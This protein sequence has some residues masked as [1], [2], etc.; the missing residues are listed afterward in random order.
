[1]APFGEEESMRRRFGHLLLSAL[2]TCAGVSGQQ[3]HRLKPG[4]TSGLKSPGPIGTQPLKNPGPQGAPATS[5]TGGS[6]VQ[7]N[8]Q[9]LPPK[10]A[11]AQKGMAV[12]LKLNTIRP[13][14]MV[15]NLSAGQAEL[16]MTNLLQ[17]Q[18]QAAEAVVATLQSSSARSPASRGVGAAPIT[19]QKTPASPQIGSEKTSSFSAAGVGT[20]PVHIDA[21]PAACGRDATMRILHVNG[22]S[23]PAT[24]TTDSRY[25]FYTITG[26]SFGDPGPNAKVYVYFQNTFREQFEIQEWNDNAIKLNLKPSLSGLL[27]Q[28]GLTLVVQRADGKQATLGGFRFYAARETKLLSRFLGRDFYLNRFTMNNIAGLQDQ[29]FSP[30]AMGASAAFPPGWTAAVQWDLASTPLQGDEDVYTFRDLQPG[31]VPDSAQGAE[32]DLDCGSN[33]LQRAGA[34]ALNWDNQ[35]ALHVHWQGQSCGIH[36]D[37][38]TFVVRA[39]NYVVNL[40]VTGPRGVDPWTG[41][42]AATTSR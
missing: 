25:N 38:D 35:N 31:F 33:S 12:K 14:A 27:D 10:G 17:A 21:G 5:L 36:G 32:I 41:K 8:P 40:W 39:A 3:Q 13:S 16:A 30:S 23:S 34:F 15:K 4:P 20:E 18:R 11:A 9:P 22:K 29:Y 42:P 28:N 19:I 2:L 7:L 37:Y 1:M 6:T 26:C 24:F